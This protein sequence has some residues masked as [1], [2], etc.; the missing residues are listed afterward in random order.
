MVASKGKGKR[1]SLVR[2][3]LTPTEHV[4]TVFQI[5][6]TGIDDSQQHKSDLNDKNPEFRQDLGIEIFENLKNIILILKI[7]SSKKYN[8]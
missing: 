3:S 5:E 7:V 6:R 4:L 1:K 8:S 2:D